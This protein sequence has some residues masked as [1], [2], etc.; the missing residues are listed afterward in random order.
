MNYHL[1]EKFLQTYPLPKLYL[2][3]QATHNQ[4]EKPDD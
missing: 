4:R 1:K 2:F 3:Y